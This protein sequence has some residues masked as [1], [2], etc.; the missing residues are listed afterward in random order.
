MKKF[1][2]A[3]AAALFLVPGVASAGPAHSLNVNDGTASDWESV[4]TVHIG[5][6][7]FTYISESG[8]DSNVNAEFHEVIQNY[9]YNFQLH[10][11]ETGPV[12]N[13]N[14]RFKVE[15]DPMISPNS[16]FGNDLD[17]NKVLSSTNVT[18]QIYSDA[19]FSS[20]I[21]T[22][23]SVDGN[24]N[25]VVYYTPAVNAIW[26]DLTGTLTGGGQLSDV[27]LEISQTP[28]PSSFVLVGIAAVGGLVYSRRRTKA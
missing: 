2:F 13:W 22:L 6:K 20:L 10:E 16:I 5:D 8:L 3:T 21:T 17:T 28:E 19:A 12:G 27:N 25:G 23:T 7:I 1:L 18:A 14:L 4:G 26:V 9:V 24:A 11:L 15:V